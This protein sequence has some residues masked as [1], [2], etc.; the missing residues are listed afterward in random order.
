MDNWICVCD[1][2]H[3][4]F[5]EKLYC[6]NEVFKATAFLQSLPRWEDPSVE[7]WSFLKNPHSFPLPN[8]S[9]IKT[10]EVGPN[11]MPSTCPYFLAVLYP[12]SSR[13]LNQSPFSDF[14]WTHNLLQLITSFYTAE[15]T[16]Y[17]Q[18]GLSLIKNLPFILLSFVLALNQ[19]TTI[20]IANFHQWICGQFWNSSLCNKERCLG[21]NPL[22]NADLKILNGPLLRHCSA[23]LW[24]W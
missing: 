21:G 20:T 16:S 13:L 12:L 8:P 6:P 19:Y 3:S 24:L 5:P 4:F 11:N 1:Y 18:W 23:S 17:I 2:S 7:R 14:C 22:E 9:M 10:T 15:N